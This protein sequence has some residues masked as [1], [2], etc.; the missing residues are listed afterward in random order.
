M[1][2]DEAAINK[3]EASLSDARKRR[4]QVGRPTLPD[5]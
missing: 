4:F 5:M 3:D 1:P 2:I